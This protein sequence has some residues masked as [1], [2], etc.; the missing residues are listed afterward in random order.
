VRTK[1]KFPF[2]REKAVEAGV[3]DLFRKCGLLVFKLSQPRA[4]MQSEGIPD[5][6]VF[7]PRRRLA[8]WWEV[9]RPGGKLSP[10]QQRFRELSLECGIGHHVGGRDE[11]RALLDELKIT[12]P[13]TPLPS[14]NQQPQQMRKTR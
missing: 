6:W 2:A 7:C 3:I 10:H 13:A 5:L 4:T 14:S 11:A 8:F 9:K 12:L 1:P